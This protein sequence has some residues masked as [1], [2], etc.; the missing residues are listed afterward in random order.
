MIHNLVITLIII[1]SIIITTKSVG[2]RK[3]I[4]GARKRN[5]HVCFHICAG[6]A[7]F[8][9]CLNLIEDFGSCGMWTMDIEQWGLGT[10]PQ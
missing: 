5:A 4:V 1:R 6:T 9:K 8:F 3:V 10:A 7:P 2:S